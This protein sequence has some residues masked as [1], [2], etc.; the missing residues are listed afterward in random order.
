MGFT[1]ATFDLANSFHV[2]NFDPYDFVNLFDK[3]DSYDFANLFNCCN[4]VGYDFEN[5]SIFKD[6]MSIGLA[7][8]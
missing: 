7:I 8:S 4:A 2:G 5:L 1:A 3:F 6:A